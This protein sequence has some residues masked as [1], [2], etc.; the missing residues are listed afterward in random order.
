MQA[1]DEVSG[2]NLRVEYVRQNARDLIRIDSLFGW[3][4]VAPKL[5]SR[6]ASAI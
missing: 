3:K 4:L 6:I 2:L 5:I 1:F